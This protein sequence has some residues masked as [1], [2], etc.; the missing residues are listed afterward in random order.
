MLSFFRKQKSEFN[1]KNNT[2]L[3]VTRVCQYSYML[4][5]NNRNGKTQKMSNYFMDSKNR[6]LISQNSSHTYF[7]QKVI[8]VLHL[9]YLED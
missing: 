2:F 5:A 9:I 1:K 6:N 3:C 4:H 7:S 8:R